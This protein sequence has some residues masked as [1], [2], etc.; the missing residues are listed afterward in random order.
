MDSTWG[1]YEFFELQTN[2]C[3][4]E[5][6]SLL[7]VRSLQ[8]RTFL[9]SIKYGDVSESLWSRPLSHFAFKRHLWTGV[10]ITLSA[11]HFLFVSE[12]SLLRVACHKHRRHF[13]T[14]SQ[15]H[16]SPT[17]FALY[18]ILFFFFCRWTAYMFPSCSDI[19]LKP[20][21]FISTSF[22]IL[23]LFSPSSFWKQC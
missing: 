20:S 4:C 19:P 8:T 14:H 2:I 15:C 21:L 10:L 7:T 11:S 5:T 12:W 9:S 22:F 6:K 17:Q 13:I 16:S 18:N 3:K 1:I 23:E